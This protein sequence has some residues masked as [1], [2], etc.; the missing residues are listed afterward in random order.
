S[1]PGGR[2]MSIAG[3]PRAHAAVSAATC[4]L[5]VNAFAPGGRGDRRVRLPALVGA[6][7]FTDLRAMVGPALTTPSGRWGPKRVPMIKALVGRSGACR[8]QISLHAVRSDDLTLAKVKNAING[9]VKG[10]IAVMCDDGE[11]LQLL[12]GD[13][14]RLREIADINDVG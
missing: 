9:E 14:I 8:G 12:V 3:S 1:R 2:P 13:C 11:V 4:K 5:S 7:P 10:S 6:M